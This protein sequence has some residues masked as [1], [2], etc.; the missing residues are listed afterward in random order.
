M[1]FSSAFKY[2][3]NNFARVFSIVLVLTIAFAIFIGLMLNSHD[4]S[5]LL[6]QIYGLDPAEHNIGE[7]GPVSGSAIVG[8]LGLLAVAIV[9]GFW[10]SGYSIEVIRSVVSDI[11]YMP[12]MEFSRN[13]KDGFYLFLSSVAYW[14]LFIVL[15]VVEVLVLQ[16]VESIGVLHLLVAAVGF[17]FTVAAMCLMGWA[18]FIGMARFALE[19]EYRASWQIRRNL[20]TSMANWRSGAALLV[21]MIFMSIIYGIMRGIVDGIFGNVGGLMIGITLSI[22]IYYF[23]NLMQHFSTQHLI[24]QFATEIGLR[25][26]N[27]D[28]EKR[29][30]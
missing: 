25:S 13:V 5:P 3:F 7:M 14:A 6:A 4:W 12:D 21:Y 16:V 17:F 28:P 30:Y 29:K 27:Y 11:E 23:F 20:E 9:S 1:S 2:P 19:G 22:V 15:I 24:A 26:D 10:L 8:L 18:Y